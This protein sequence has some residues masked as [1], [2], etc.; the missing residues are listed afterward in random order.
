MGMKV[1]KDHLGNEF[2]SQ[3][4]MCECWRINT[5]TFIN[6][7]KSGYSLEEA[8]TQPCRSDKYRPCEDHLGN[9]F[10]SV[11]DMCKYHGIAP[12]TFATRRKFG[13]SIEKCLSTEI[14][15]A[16]R[17]V[18][19]TDHLGNEFPS[20]R[21]MCRFWKIDVD[22]FTERIARGY[23]LEEALTSKPIIGKAHPCKD[24]LDN[25]FPS[26]SAMCRF[27][28]ININTFEVRKKLG[29]SLEECLTG[30]KKSK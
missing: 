12:S 14:S 19:C 17:A 11:K 7:I 16:N 15:L 13:W 22:T 9:K 18:K 21:A 20:K 3:K 24:H 5:T 27:W 26:K 25:E 30:R 1:W 23:S 8:L 28:S 6:R 2:E 4:A 29:Y 10:D